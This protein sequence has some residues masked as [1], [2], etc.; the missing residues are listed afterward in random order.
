MSRNRTVRKITSGK[1]ASFENEIEI[2]NKKYVSN[3]SENNHKDKDKKKFS[4]KPKEKYEDSFKVE[5]KYNKNKV[6][7]LECIEQKNNIVETKKIKDERNKN[8][9]K[10]EVKPKI[11]KDHKM[12]KP[13]KFE[14]LFSVGSSKELNISDSNKEFFLRKINTNLNA[15]SLIEYCI[16]NLE[17]TKKIFSFVEDDEYDTS[18]YEKSNHLLVV[19]EL[20]ITDKPRSN[21]DNGFRKKFL[22]SSNTLNIINF[23]EYVKIFLNT[24]GFSIFNSYFMEDNMI[25]N[26]SLNYFN[27]EDYLNSF[28]KNSHIKRII[29]GSERY[30]NKVIFEGNVK[31][32]KEKKI[33]KLEYRNCRFEIND[34]SKT[35]KIIDTFN[36]VEYMAKSKVTFI[37][38]EAL[39]NY[40]VN[41]SYND[42]KPHLLSYIFDFDKL[43]NLSKLL[44]KKISDVVSMSENDREGTASLLVELTEK[45]KLMCIY[46]GRISIYDYLYESLFEINKNT[47]LKELEIEHK[48]IFDMIASDLL[49]VKKFFNKSKSEEMSF[50]EINNIINSIKDKSNLVLSKFSLIKS[51]KDK[52]IALYIIYR[53][54]VNSP[55]YFSLSENYVLNF[56]LE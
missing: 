40:L 56:G 38:N 18:D 12:P 43:V 8:H 39:L 32:R 4:D 47:N 19:K 1:K 28:Y 45:E 11:L 52:L 22:R 36:N 33:Y 13:I 27:K 17:E 7:K 35:L 6:E 54:I 31:H 2:W 10:K 26:F 50:K 37:S 24:S 16:D 15:L 5:S 30:L 46:T 3:N 51:N 41:Y 23:L 55:K 29:N 48:M 9:F 20:K 25:E 42:V 44:K 14:P 49:T 53:Y 21:K 34:K